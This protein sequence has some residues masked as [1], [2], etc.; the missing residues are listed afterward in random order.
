MDGP[1]VVLF[2]KDSADETGDG[3]FVGEDADD[4]S[5]PLDLAIE[6]LDRI[7]AVQ[8]GTVLGGERHIGQHIFLGI[9][10]ESSQL[11]YGGT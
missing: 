5:A 4:I 6:P 8:L 2:Q 9:V 7:V 11:G 1:F 10:H 3:F